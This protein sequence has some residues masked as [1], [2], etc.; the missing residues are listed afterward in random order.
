M[1]QSWAKNWAQF[2]CETNEIEIIESIGVFFK[3]DNFLLSDILNTSRRT[4]LEEFS[5]TFFNIKSMLPTEHSDNISVEQISF[6]KRGCFD[7]FSGKEEWFFIHIR[8]RIRN[9]SGNIRSKK[10]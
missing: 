6:Y 7:L 3:I 2:T 4:K 8:E 1:Y 10:K 9:H 5:D